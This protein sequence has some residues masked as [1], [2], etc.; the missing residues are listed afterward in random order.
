MIVSEGH[1]VPVEIEL[2]G[3]D[4][5]R[6]R[7]RLGHLVDHDPLVLYEG[8][9]ADP[10]EARLDRSESRE[11][12][13]VERLREDSA[14][15]GVVHHSRVPEEID[16]LL[17]YAGIEVGI[18]QLHDVLRGAPVTLEYF[19]HRRY[20]LADEVRRYKLRVSDVEPTA[21]I[22]YQDVLEGGVTYP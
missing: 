17:F 1:D 12:G 15:Q 13:R 6:V 20:P 14:V 19:S 4:P 16:E 18:L 10:N 11:A 9:Q 3:A 2:V 22:E 8:E 7:R 21:G 5:G